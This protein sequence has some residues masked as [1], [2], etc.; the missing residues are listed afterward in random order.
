M[1]PT[2]PPKLRSTITFFL[3]ATGLF[4][5]LLLLNSPHEG[6]NASLHWDAEASITHGPNCSKEELAVARSHLFDCLADVHSTT[7][8]AEI[9]RYYWSSEAQAKKYNTALSGC[10]YY[11]SAVADWCGHWGFEFGRREFHTPLAA[12]WTYQLTAAA[13]MAVALALLATT[14]FASKSKPVVWPAFVA[15]AAVSSSPVFLSLSR[16]WLT[17]TPG[18]VFFALTIGCVQLALKFSTNGAER[19]CRRV[20][21]SAN[22]GTDEEKNR[23]QSRP[24]LS[25]LLAVLSGGLAFAT[26][27]SRYTMGPALAMVLP[28]IAL[29]NPIPARRWIGLSIAFLTPLIAMIVTDIILFGPFITPAVYGDVMVRSS[30]LFFHSDDPYDK[31]IVAVWENLTLLLI[32]LMVVWTW[33]T[34]ARR[35]IAARL[36]AALAIAIVAVMLWRTAAQQVQFQG[37]HLFPLAAVGIALMYV[38]LPHLRWRP[39]AVIGFTAVAGFLT[40]FNVCGTFGA[41]RRHETVGQPYMVT[42]VEKHLSPDGAK[43]PRSL[44]RD[45]WWTNFDWSDSRLL[46]DTLL[47]WNAVANQN[48]LVMIDAA[49]ANGNQFAFY[50]RQFPAFM[51]IHLKDWNDKDNLATAR[52]ALAHGQP[53]YL[54]TAPGRR[55][56]ADVMIASVDHSVDL[57]AAALWRVTKASP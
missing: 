23:R 18:F 22:G 46:R 3:L 26:I 24:A 9:T 53:V 19:L 6:I 4:G 54:L 56:P 7:D 1:I 38:V 17:E 20:L 12:V 57:H 51:T 55:P 8:P 21:S 10:R 37:R 42:V 50:A 13:A 48:A 16:Q 49:A 27:R 40:V 15:T 29:L 28:I 25:L 14:V 33:I 41:Q 11:Y 34:T 31:F 45:L 30:R 32:P 44:F 2:P 5:W 36:A 43:L 52:A 39:A 47:V 35:T